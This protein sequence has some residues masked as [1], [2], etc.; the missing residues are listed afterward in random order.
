MVRRDAITV[1]VWMAQWW[2]LWVM[3]H[4]TMDTSW[5]SM[6]NTSSNHQFWGDM[7]VF[8]GVYQDDGLYNVSPFKY[9][10]I[11]GIYV[12]FQVLQFN[13]WVKENTTVSKAAT[14]F[15]MVKSKSHLAHFYDRWR[16]ENRPSWLV[17][18]MYMARIWVWYPV[19]GRYRATQ[20]LWQR[21]HY[22][23][24]VFSTNPG[25][26]LGFL[27]H[28]QYRLTLCQPALS[29][30][31]VLLEPVGRSLIVCFFNLRM[32]KLLH[33]HRIHGTGIFIYLFTIKIN[34][35]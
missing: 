24:R 12:K 1:G 30:W 17:K 18:Y 4:K 33:T 19:D 15:K 8:R 32:N 16:E 3:H 10:V 26:C 21:Y 9:G 13:S 20:L 14:G 35:M 6:G 2:K 29:R 5:F 25:G 28:Q 11:L 22:L 27:N 34:Q 7:L 23:R 31:S